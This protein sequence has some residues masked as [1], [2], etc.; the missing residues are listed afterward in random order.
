LSRETE[1]LDKVFE[2]THGYPYFLQEWGY[3]AW[4]HAELSP[5]SMVAFADYF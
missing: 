2:L 1:A 3:S 5:I 4:N